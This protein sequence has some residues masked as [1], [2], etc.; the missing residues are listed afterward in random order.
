MRSF[1]PDVTALLTQKPL[2]TVSHAAFI[3][4]SS[5]CG[6]KPLATL[7]WPLAGQNRKR[8][9]TGISE[10][11][12]LQIYFKKASV[13]MKTSIHSFI[14]FHAC[15]IKKHFSFSFD[16]LFLQLIIRICNS[17]SSHCSLSSW[18]YFLPKLTIHFIFYLVKLSDWLGP[19]LI[20]EGHYPACF[21]VSQLRHTWF[22]D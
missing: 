18:P 7:C 16:K 10:G 12:S 22:R 9:Q 14:L 8:K 13:H 15:E 2:L 11:S 1:C 3:A 20:P 6:F 21:L 5:I 19:F 4:S 17:C